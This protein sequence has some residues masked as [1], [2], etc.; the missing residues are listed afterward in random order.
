MF[1]IVILVFCTFFIINRLMQILGSYDSTDKQKTRDSFINNFMKQRYANTDTQ[2][3][4]DVEVIPAS[5]LALSLDQRMVLKQIR[6]IDSTFDLDNFLLGVKKAYSIIVNAINSNDRKTLENLVESDIINSFMEENR[7][8]SIEAKN[9]RFENAMIYGDRAIIRTKIDLN[10]WT[11]TR[12]LTQ[13]KIWRVS[14]F[15]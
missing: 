3:I 5:E 10:Y 9:V 6:K 13:D 14:K 8:I 4:V 11:F 15:Q 1:D 12:Y 2:Q 7:K